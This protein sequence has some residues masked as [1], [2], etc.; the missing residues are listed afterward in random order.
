MQRDVLELAW[1]STWA[2]ILK[3]LHVLDTTGDIISA[4]EHREIHSKVRRLRK[5]T[6]CYRKVL[7]R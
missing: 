2:E 1:L 6:Q 3:L 5:K 7:R 4:E